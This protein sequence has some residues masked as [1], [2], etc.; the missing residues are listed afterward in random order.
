MGARADGLQGHCEAVRMSRYAR[1]DRDLCRELYATEGTYAG[2]QR[3]LNAR[4]ISAI[5]GTVRNILS[6][7]DVKAAGRTTSSRFAATF[8]SEKVARLPAIGNAAFTEKRTLYPNTVVRDLDGANI[9][10][11]GINSSKIGGVVRK[12]KWKGMPIYTLTLEERAT[13]PT[14]C[15]HWRSCFGNKMQFAQRLDHTSPQFETALVRHVAQL[16]RQHP[17]G[18]VVRLHVLGDFFSVRYV[19]LWQ[20]MLDTIPALKV[21][22]YSARWDVRADPIAAAL[23]PIVMA[24]WDRFAIR[25]SDAPVDECSTVSLEHPIQKPADAIIC[26][27][28]AGGTESCSTCALCWQS[29][30]RIAFIQH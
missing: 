21:F 24:R 19:N 20:A 17:A 12:G 18:F 5:Y 15:S 10:K 29:K 13:C 22:G 14:S 26:P 1:I 8:S 9:L 4:G 2:V 28:Q 16:A 3:A 25:F 23:V 6:G 27:E 11:A 30:R 7:K